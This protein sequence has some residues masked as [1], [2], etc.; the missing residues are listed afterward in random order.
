MTYLLRLSPARVLLWSYLIWYLVVLARYFDSAPSLWI[1]SLGIS[2]VIGSALYV[3]T[4]HSGS[5]QTRLD[6]WQVFRLYL[7]PFCVSS[8]AAL[9]KDRHFVFIFHPTLRDNAIAFALIGGFCTTIFSIQRL[10]G[11]AG[12]LSAEP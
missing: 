12:D 8:F 11:G 4:V 2:V 10:S 1:N 5:R 7:M 3:S 6:R 9:I